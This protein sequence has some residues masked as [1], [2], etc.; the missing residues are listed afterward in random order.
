MHTRTTD[1]N[2]LSVGVTVRQLPNGTVEVETDY[3]A[4]PLRATGATEDEAVNSL[5]ELV[6]QHLNSGEP[7]LGRVA[8]ASG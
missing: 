7:A 5:I 6:A 3:F 4:P 2:T 8:T 1:P